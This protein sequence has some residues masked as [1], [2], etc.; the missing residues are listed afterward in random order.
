MEGVTVAVVYKSFIG[1]KRIQTLTLI[2]IKKQNIR[3]G[4]LLH[5]H[6]V[7]CGDVW[8]LQEFGIGSNAQNIL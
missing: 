7:V 3:P 1:Y 6:V 8:L 5:V 2:T 4:W